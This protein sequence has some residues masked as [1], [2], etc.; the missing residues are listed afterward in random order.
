MSIERGRISDKKFTKKAVEIIDILE[1]VIGQADRFTKDETNKLNK[2]ADLELTGEQSKVQ[3]SILD[4]NV[5]YLLNVR[6]ERVEKI[7]DEPLINEYLQKLK[8]MRGER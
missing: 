5:K 4:V 2:F 3:K 1:D 7:D 8:G 6:P